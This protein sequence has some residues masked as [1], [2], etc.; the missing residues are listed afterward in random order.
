MT[1]ARVDD[2]VGC[3]EYDRL[4]KEYNSLRVT[5]FNE[6]RDQVWADY[7]S[8][9]GA[10]YIDLQRRGCEV[11]ELNPEPPTFEVPERAPLADLLFPKVH[12]N[13]KREEVVDWPSETH[14]CT[15]VT[16]L[17]SLCSRRCSPA[18]RTKEDERTVY[19]ELDW[20]EL[21]V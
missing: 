15:L 13:V 3:A 16:L 1:V 20:L 9:V 21:I 7:F 17:A 8:T 14:H 10:R 18:R 19:I 12:E 5:S 6:R 11:T 4:R 2:P